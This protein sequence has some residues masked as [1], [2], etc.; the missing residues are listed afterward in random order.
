MSVDHSMHSSHSSSSTSSTLP[1]LSSTSCPP[2]TLPSTPFLHSPS[3]HSQQYQH[4]TS[5]TEISH[6]SLISTHIETSSGVTEGVSVSSELTEERVSL[7]EE[8]ESIQPINS[9]SINQ[10]RASTNQMGKS[11]GISSEVAPSLFKQSE[12]NLHLDECQLVEQSSISVETE[13]KQ[14]HMQMYTSMPTY[15]MHSMIPPAI[16]DAPLV[17]ERRRSAF[18]EVS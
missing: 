8:V 12:N 7:K 9:D 18:G 13:I 11:E 2:P 1:S 17:R 16:P 3:N 10:L 4:I 14:P 5:I 15:S 6:P